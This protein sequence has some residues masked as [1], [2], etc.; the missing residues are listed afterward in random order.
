M[1][2]NISKPGP[3]KLSNN[4]GLDEWLEESKKCHYLPEKAMKELCE[5]VKE[6]LMEGILQWELSDHCLIFLF[7]NQ[8]FSRFRRPSL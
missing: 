5:M 3:A 7:Q 2:P 4:A 6:C 1:S 8:I